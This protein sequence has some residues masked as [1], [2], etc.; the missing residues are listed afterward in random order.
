MLAETFNITLD[1]AADYSHVFTCYNASNQLMTVLASEFVGQVREV[2]GRTKVADFAFE[3]PVPASGKV[4]FILPNES[5]KLLR[6]SGK[7]EYDI[8]RVTPS[9]TLRLLY[10]T[11]VVR[12]NITNIESL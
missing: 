8:F 10:G 9:M 5:T 12:A 7:Y 11:L 6:S 1:R 4:Q 2:N 3:T